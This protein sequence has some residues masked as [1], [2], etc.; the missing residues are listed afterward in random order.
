[1]PKTTTK[2]KAK[3]KS[4]EKPQDKSKD[5]AK[6]KSKDKS[7]EKPQ[8]K[9]K[10]KSK[11]VE[12]DG[13]VLFKNIDILAINKTYFLGSITNLTTKTDKRTTKLT[14]S[15]FI[16]LADEI[17]KPRSCVV[18]MVDENKHKLPEK[19]C[20]WW[21]RNK[22]EGS[23]VGCPIKYIPSQIV[24]TY[25]SEI[26][27][28]SY[29]IK[30][31]ISKSTR[32]KEGKKGAESKSKAPTPKSKDSDNIIYDAKV[33]LLKHEYYLVEGIFCSF[34]CCLAY[35]LD[36]KKNP[37]LAQSPFL[38]R[39]LFT[40]ILGEKVEFDILPAP[41][42]KLLKDYGGHLSIEEFR[43][44]FNHVEYIEVAN[45]RELPQQQKIKNVYEEKKR[46]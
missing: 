24:K 34:N 11:V 44:S 39:K 26:T 23:P 20:C 3:E 33:D 38:L 21:C 25:N 43:E 29:S 2:D 19:K 14:S 41:S 36:N 8:D 13:L 35:I 45:L 5:K 17:K 12:I 22:F 9:A 37:K 32:K 28:N 7:K 46:I 30:E 42:W 16:N 4:K 40:D 10:E 18:T 1:M 27:K 31:N 15:V 6:D